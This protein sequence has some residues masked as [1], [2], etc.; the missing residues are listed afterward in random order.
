MKHI[1]LTLSVVAL[2]NTR[3]QERNLTMKRF[4]LSKLMT[5]GALSLSMAILPLVVRVS[6]QNPPDA[7]DSSPVPTYQTTTQERG[8]DWGW[9]GLL[10]LLGLG[11][12]ARRPEEPVAYREPDVASRSAYRE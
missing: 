5:V 9:L 7:T 8:F 1:C 4:N 10:G 6:A 2:T 11:G 12:L 3:N